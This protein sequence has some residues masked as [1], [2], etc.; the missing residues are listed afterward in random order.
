MKINRKTYKGRGRPRVRDYEPTFWQKWGSTIVWF[1]LFNFTVVMWFGGAV[2]VKKA[3]AEAQR[4]FL[5]PTIEVTEW[6]YTFVD[7]PVHKEKSTI[8]SLF[9]K[10][11]WNAELMTAICKSE[12]GYVYQG[13][14]EDAVFEGNSDGSTDTG[15]CMIN[16]N[17]FADFVRRGKLN[18]DLDLTKAEDNIY[19]A[20]VIWTE[21]GC[22][23]WTKCR[24]KGYLFY[25]GEK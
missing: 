5:N 16:S 22:N 15:L 20:Y 9:Y 8:E 2:R 21:Q 11:D 14:K 10:Y 3:Y 19:S 17:T 6:T 13:W 7:E 12:V 4:P 1:I 23:A 25:M 24:D 18:P